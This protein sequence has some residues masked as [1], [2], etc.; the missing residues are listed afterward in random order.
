MKP[1]LDET[2]Q[3]GWYRCRIVSTET[4]AVLWWSGLRLFRYDDCKT[5]MDMK[6]VTDFE[7]MEVVK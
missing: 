4:H 6:M 5:G 3:P 2:D 1:R 7:R